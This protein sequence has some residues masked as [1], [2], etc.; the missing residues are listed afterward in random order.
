[1]VWTHRRCDEGDIYFISNQE[2]QTRTVD[3]AFRV[4]DRIPELWDAE[5]G[6]IADAPM[7]RQQ[8][9]RT[10]V[11][12]RLE[13]CASI[14]VVFRRKGA[15]VDPI[16]TIKALHVIEPSSMPA[17]WFEDGRAWATQDGRWSLS[18]QSGKIE[19]V[20][21]KG[22]PK[23]IAIPGRWNVTFPAGFGA[24]EQVELHRGD[25]RIV[26]VV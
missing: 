24:P 21:L 25:V 13:P 20:A 1:M 12:L 6:K 11:S 4:A 15:G 5:T 7:W 3:V 22:L 16:S 23:A 14:F 8:N 18:R 19:T 26:Q 2:R 17:L 10:F 9:G